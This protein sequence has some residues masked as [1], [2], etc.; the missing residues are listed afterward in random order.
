MGICLRSSNEAA[1]MT[2]RKKV[3]IISENKMSLL[4][5]MNSENMMSNKVES[6]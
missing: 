6:L 2:S 5:G 1:A 3:L 4:S